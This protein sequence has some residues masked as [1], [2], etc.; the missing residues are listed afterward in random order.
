MTK[1]RARF[2]GFAAAAAVAVAAGLGAGG[3]G[4]G[5]GTTTG[6]RPH[7]G[8]R[9]EGD[10]YH[11]VVLDAHLDYLQPADGPGIDEGVESFVPSKDEVARFEQAA[12]AAL[13][14]AGNPSGDDDVTA[15]ELRTYL[16]QYTGVAATDAE[17]EHLRQVVVQGVCSQAS[18]DMD[19]EK[20]W[21]QV[22]DGGTCF[23][24]A[25]LDLG[26]GDIIRFGFHGAA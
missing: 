26:S 9:V 20:A 15:R 19:W 13:A 23:W 1:S 7:S 12:P 10:G 22:A 17:G 6:D 5:D 11:G 14:R 8:D 25:T 16:R 18:D 4:D 24:D 3:C 2:V 21:V